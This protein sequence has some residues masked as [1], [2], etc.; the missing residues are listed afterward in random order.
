MSPVVAFAGVPSGVRQSGLCRRN[1]GNRFQMSVVSSHGVSPTE[2][3]PAY[4]KTRPT[5]SPVLNT[6]ENKLLET[7]S[8]AIKDPW[9]LS[10]TDEQPH[11]PRDAS[12]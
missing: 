3:I 5:F 10:C 11:R 2:S 1:V 8:L 4:A 7:H 9:A 6:L 12:H